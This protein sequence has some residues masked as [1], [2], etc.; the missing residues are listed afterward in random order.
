MTKHLQLLTISAIIAISAKAQAPELA[1]QISFNPQL[2]TARNV[3]I[4]GANGS[5]GGEINAV[6][7]N[8]AG[9]GMYKNPE[10]VFSSAF[11]LN[12]NKVNYRETTSKNKRNAYS[13]APIGFVVP[14]KARYD[15]TEKSTTTFTVALS[16]TAD[17]TN[18]FKYNGYNNYSSGAEQFIEELRN[19]GLTVGQA[20]NTQ[21]QV[22]YGAAPALYTYLIDTVTIAGQKKI[23]AAT[24]NILNA[25]QALR[26]EVDKKIN[27]GIYELALGLGKEI[28]K[29]WLVGG[30][31]NFSLLHRKTTTNFTESDSSNN[32][33]NGF[34][35]FV[36]TDNL[37]ANGFGVN[38]KI[39]II[40]RP[41]DYIRLG[42]AVHT[43][44]ITTITEERS[45]NLAT[46]LENP[47]GSFAVGSSTF[48]TTN[49]NKFN[50]VTPFKLI[51]SGSYVFREVENVKKQK[52]FI[53]A[54]I[55][56][57]AHRGSRFA[58]AEE[59]PSTADEAYFKDLNN[60]VKD[61][62]KNTLNFR[63]G[64]EVKFN[65]IM[66]RLGVAYYG[67]PYADKELKA[68]RT[69]LSGGLGYRD[70]GIFIDLTYAH[71]FNKDVNFAY[72]LQD[73]DNTFATTKNQRGQI[74]ATIGFKL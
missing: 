17:F 27:G 58:S 33:N 47:V 56:Y 43:P 45:T 31:I 49:E 3:A 34:K 1:G 40:Y 65:T 5:L 54:D 69:I 19:S 2:G 59:N 70:K 15:K 25:G 41:Q 26:Q 16:Q 13:L 11:A 60:V 21:S 4:G 62:Y 68:N 50:L 18:T 28:N 55:E 74:V 73:K 12:N 10:F 7:V 66:A 6:F 51:A 52:A 24:D 9:I 42:L 37:T 30:A 53:T 39:G 22:P 61:Y 20:L 35:N 38:A 64:G 48:T 8:P 14:I 46:S 32:N 71:Q 72:R 36:F 67:N 63:L 44:T 57:V 23:I 29:K